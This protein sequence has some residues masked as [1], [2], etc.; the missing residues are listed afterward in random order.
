[1]EN[2]REYYPIKD[3]KWKLWSMPLD[4][5]FQADF[6]YR[7]LL[8]R[9]FNFDPVVLRIFL[10]PSRKYAVPTD[11]YWRTSSQNDRVAELL[12]AKTLRCANNLER[13]RTLHLGCVLFLGPE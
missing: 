7:L 1:M 3:L 2:A 13:D 12:K 8:P 4:I 10:V 11:T 9:L 6:F 5:S